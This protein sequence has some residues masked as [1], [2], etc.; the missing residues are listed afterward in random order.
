[1]EALAREL[2]QGG[3]L[4]TC[5]YMNINKRGGLASADFRSLGKYAKKYQA[6]IKKEIEILKKYP[7]LPQSKGGLFIANLSNLDL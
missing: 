2:N 1:M 5:A 3:M 7:P 6:F 4:E